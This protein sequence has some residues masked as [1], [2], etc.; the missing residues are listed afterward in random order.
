[1]S[2]LS[3]S[4]PVVAMAALL[5]TQAAPA[6]AVSS[7]TL[8]VVVTITASGQA[9]GSVTVPMTIQI[10]RYTPE[11]WRTQ[12]TDGLKQQGGYPGFLRALRQAPRA[13]GLEVG[14]QK[15]VIRWAH[16]EPGPAG[17]TLTFVTDAPVYFVGSGRRGA[18]PTAGYE[19]AAIKLTMDGKG[20]GEG[21][22]AAAARVKP[23]GTGGVIV[24]N[25]AEAPMT[26]VAAVRAPR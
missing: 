16:Q 1:V 13:G 24:D 2:V 11:H 7:E 21:T 12:M 19:V 8:D 5:S 10:E 14:G 15:Y 3:L 25:Y 26:L 22:M 9:K 20:Q 6:P 18:K 4:I 17:R 23:D